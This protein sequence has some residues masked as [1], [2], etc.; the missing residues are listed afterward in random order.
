MMGNAQK[1]RVDH[2]AL[3]DTLKPYADAEGF[4]TK[5]GLKAAMQARD[6]YGQ[7]LALPPKAVFL[8]EIDTDH[9]GKV[10][11]E[12]AKKWNGYGGKSYCRTL[13]D[14]SYGCVSKCSNGLEI[15]DG[16]F[17]YFSEKYEV[18]KLHVPNMK[19]NEE[20]G[21]RYY[22][23]EWSPTQRVAVEH[24]LAS[25]LHKRIGGAVVQ[26]GLKD[27]NSW[28][29]LRNVVVANTTEQDEPAIYLYD[30]FEGLPECD[31]ELDSGMCPQ[32][33]SHLVSY[34]QVK[35]DVQKLRKERRALPE[36]MKFEFGAIPGNRLPQ[37]ISFAVLDGALYHQTEAM[38][39]KVYPRLAVGG[40]IVVHDFGWEGYPG[41]EK[42]VEVFSEANGAKVRLPG[43]PDGVACYLAEITKVTG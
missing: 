12:E 28:R 8:A 20:T 6:K 15:F 24:L 35:D 27:P 1:T 9:D 31:H 17:G 34:Q 21:K 33:G 10:S 2:H 4:V 36:V 13:G 16:N 3:W 37:Q 22:H 41:I 19:L 11:Q 5:S 39:H 42:A 38:L 40:K 14:A 32:K 26:M 23:G 25:T 18:N 29:H 7:P 43:G 30:N